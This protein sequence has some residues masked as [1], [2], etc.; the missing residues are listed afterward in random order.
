MPMSG[1]GIAALQAGAALPSSGETCFIT[2][3]VIGPDVAVRLAHEEAVT[4]ANISSWLRRFCARRCCQS[5][6]RQSAAVS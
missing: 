5:F 6:I 1:P 4:T 3:Y 2:R